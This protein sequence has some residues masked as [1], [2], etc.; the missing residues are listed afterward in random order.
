MSL[1]F[2]VLFNLIKIIFIIK[3]ILNFYKII[4]VTN[5]MAVNCT[6][7]K[8]HRPSECPYLSNILN[9]KTNIFTKN[10]SNECQI[11]KATQL[12]K[13]KGENRVFF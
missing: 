12:Q 4:F 1:A 13:I 2:A 6:K 7:L 9:F 5:I 8:P 3:N 11:P 10:I